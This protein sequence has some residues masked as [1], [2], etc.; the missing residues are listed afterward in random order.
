MGR[1]PRSR[2]P[3]PHPIVVKRRAPERGDRVRSVL[4]AAP[5]LPAERPFLERAA[6]FLTLLMVLVAFGADYLAPRNLVGAMVPI[7]ALTPSSRH[8][9]A[10]SRSRS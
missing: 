7:T 10:A 1:E 4:R 8:T 2:P 3:H 9:S 5:A 6:S